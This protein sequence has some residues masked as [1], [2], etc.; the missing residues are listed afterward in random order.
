MSIELLFS[1]N[2]CHKE[3]GERELR[4]T[5]AKYNPHILNVLV[6]SEEKKIPEENSRY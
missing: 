5:T 4:V 2:Q 6:L 3:N 1:T